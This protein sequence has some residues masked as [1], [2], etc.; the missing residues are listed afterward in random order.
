MVFFHMQR[1]TE[2]DGFYDGAKAAPLPFAISCGRSRASLAETNQFYRFLA[3]GERRARRRLSRHAL[4]EVAIIAKGESSNIGIVTARENAIL[5]IW[6]SDNLWIVIAGFGED[7]QR[8]RGNLGD[9][10]CKTSER[11]SSHF[12]ESMKRKP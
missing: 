12:F 7:N 9:A 4:D 3:F 8:T 5:I 6:R 2:L 11:I 1:Q 10:S